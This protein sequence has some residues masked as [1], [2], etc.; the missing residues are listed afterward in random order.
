[1]SQ[2]IGV[3]LTDE[4]MF[5]LRAQAVEMDKNEAEIVREALKEY[6][7]RKGIKTNSRLKW[8]G[9]RTHSKGDSE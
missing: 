4:L 6:F 2:R 5:A 9:K 1:M 3:T 8:G 7:K